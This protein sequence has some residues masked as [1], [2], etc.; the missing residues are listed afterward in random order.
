M[1]VWYCHLCGK[2]VTQDNRPNEWCNGGSQ[3]PSMCQYEAIQE[4]GDETWYC[5]TCGLRV[6]VKGQ[7]Y[8]THC[9]G[10]DLQNWHKW[11]R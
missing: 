9:K 3:P 8:M 2:T 6:R 4:A 5:R 10:T 11:D 7:P 1:T